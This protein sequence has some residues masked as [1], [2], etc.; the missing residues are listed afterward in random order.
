MSDN[1]VPLDTEFLIGEKDGAIGRMIFNNPERRNAVKL[2]MWEAMP[3]VLD[4]FEADDDIKV[5]VLQGAGDQAF[6]SGADISEFAEVRATP[7]STKNYENAADGAM[8]RLSKCP[9]PTI[10]MIRG[11]CMGG[12]AGIAVSCDIRMASDDS[13]FGVPA[14][15]LGVGYRVGGIAKLVDLVGPSFAK[16]IFYTGRPFDAQEAVTMGLVN[17]LFKPEDL[18]AGVD[19][20]CNI[21]AGNA[22]LTIA[23]VKEMVGQII[24]HD[25][26]IDYDYC[27]NLV[28]ECFASEDYIEGRTAFMDKRKPVFR[29]R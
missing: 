6:I 4:A 21:I 18:Q 20:Y 5:V 11:W 23:S 15:K 17:R 10:A 29:G 27:E 24:N 16:E 14:A 19:D 28:D 8:A 12:G 25:K 26:P 3:A 13:R 1:R 2:S 7:E 9:K 22:P